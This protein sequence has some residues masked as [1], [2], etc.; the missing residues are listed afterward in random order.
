[1][2]PSCGLN[3]AVPIFGSETSIDAKRRCIETLR[4]LAVRNH[5]SIRPDLWGNLRGNAFGDVDA[6]R[7]APRQPEG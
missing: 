4:G 1:M 7:T 2:D 6:A 5:A 3:T